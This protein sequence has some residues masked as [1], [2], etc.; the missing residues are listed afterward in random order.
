MKTTSV[1]TKNNDVLQWIGFLPPDIETLLEVKQI[2][3]LKYILTNSVA[4]KLLIQDRGY[5]W[6]IKWLRLYNE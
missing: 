2:I 5:D 4:I 3:T 6:L 1:N